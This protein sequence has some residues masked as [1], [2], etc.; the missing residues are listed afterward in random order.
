MLP[1]CGQAD[2]WGPPEKAGAHVAMES[3]TKYQSP[4]TKSSFKNIY[5][6]YCLLVSENVQ[7]DSIHTPSQHVSK[8]PCLCPPPAPSL[9]ARSCS[10]ISPTQTFHSLPPSLSSLPVPLLLLPLPWLQPPTHTHTPLSLVELTARDWQ[11]QILLRGQKGSP[12][13]TQ[14]RTHGI[15]THLDTSGHAA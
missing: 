15:Q 10:R 1:Y 14:P 5:S 2:I 7:G 9:T 3:S 13:I 11:L 6:N 12:Q 8:A 4:G